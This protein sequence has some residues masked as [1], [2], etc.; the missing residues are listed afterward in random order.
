ML[1]YLTDRTLSPAGSVPPNPSTDQDEPILFKNGD[2]TPDTEDKELERTE[3]PANLQQGIF[4]D[5]P[6]ALL[7]T[8]S[9]NEQSGNDCTEENPIKQNSAEE[10]SSEP[11]V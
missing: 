5:P 9:T 2:N 4:G 6:V 7:D 10:E 3:I 8:S 11:D 1:T